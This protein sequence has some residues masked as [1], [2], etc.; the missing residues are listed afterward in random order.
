[1]SVGIVVDNSGSM[2][3]KRKGVNSAALKFVQSSNPKD[4]VFIVNFNEEA[5][6]DAD[7]TD[8][9]KLLEEALEKID[10][11]G[12]TAF[13]DAIQMSLA[14]LVEKATRDKKVLL[15]ITDGEDN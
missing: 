13:Y 8:N 14:H 1:M 11:R 2:R 3:D 4:E 10:A 6:L 5:F 7:F 9:V 15:L 12:G